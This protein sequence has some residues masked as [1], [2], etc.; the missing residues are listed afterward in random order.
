MDVFAEKSEKHEMLLREAI[1]VLPHVVQFWRER[2]ENDGIPCADNLATSSVFTDLLHISTIFG[3][4]SF[5]P[6]EVF[7]FLTSVRRGPAPAAGQIVQK[8]CGNHL[9]QQQQGNKA[10]SSFPLSPSETAHLLQE[11]GRHGLRCKHFVDRIIHFA[12][13]QAESAMTVHEIMD[14]ARG[15]IRFTKDWQ[16]FF[17]KACPKIRM[18]LLQLEIPDLLLTLRFSRDLKSCGYGSGMLYLE[19][20]RDVCT[21]LRKKML[22]EEEGSGAGTPSQKEN[23]SSSTPTGSSFP[24]SEA[25]RSL[26]DVFFDKRYSRAVGEY[27]KAVNGK[28][29]DYREKHMLFVR[30]REIENQRH[31][32]ENEQQDSH[33]SHDVGNSR[34]RQNDWTL[35]TDPELDNTVELVRGL[36]SLTSWKHVFLVSQNATPGTGAPG[37]PQESSSYQLQEPHFDSSYLQNLHFLTNILA[38]RMPEMKYS[39]NVSL[40]QSVTNSLS[41]ISINSSNCDSTASAVED[42]GSLSNM[43]SSSDDYLSKSWLQQLLPVIQDKYMLDRISFFQQCT[44]VTALARMKFFDKTAYD[45][46]SFMLLQERQLFTELEHLSPVLWAY[47]LMKYHPNKPLFEF[48]FDFVEEK[49]EGLNLLRKN[50]YSKRGRVGTNNPNGPPTSSGGGPEQQLLSQV[51]YTALVQCC[52][53]FVSAGW[54]EVPEEEEIRKRLVQLQQNGLNYASG[55]Q[56]VEQDFNQTSYQEP[57]DA[58]LREERAKFLWRQ[59]RLCKMLDSVFVKQVTRAALDPYANAGG[60]G[61]VNTTRL[62]ERL[63]QIAH[64]IDITVEKNAEKRMELFS[65]EGL[66][67]IELH[68]GQECNTCAGGF[69]VG[70]RQQNFAQNANNMIVGCPLSLEEGGVSVELEQEAAM[71]DVAQEQVASGRPTV[72]SI[73][74]QQ[75]PDDKADATTPTSTSFEAE[76]RKKVSDYFQNKLEPEGASPTRMLSAVKMSR[77]ELLHGVY[78]DWVLELVQPE[79][80]ASTGEGEDAER[81]NAEKIAVFLLTSNVQTGGSFIRK[82]HSSSQLDGESVMQNNPHS[83]STAFNEQ[84]NLLLDSDGRQAFLEEILSKHGV[85]VVNLFL[86]EFLPS[87]RGDAED[88]RGAGTLVAEILNQKLRCFVN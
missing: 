68:L 15:L 30:E 64:M 79:K 21:L 27:V 47:S 3:K 20:Q 46:I 65:P 66:K 45:S 34:I 13:D 11:T 18:N 7:D 77:N 57:S 56:D 17:H 29:A 14:S 76:I 37:G 75:G 72:S 59:K 2:V 71:L 78:C 55:E 69:S 49:V 42:V 84:V 38:E 12:A 19:L 67:R 4:H 82:T 24:L 6:G 25:I 43:T 87:G 85:K 22:L 33:S 62:L 86:P 28:L 80:T 41:R 74:E 31:R 1:P 50:F 81:Q 70:G 23:L 63:V 88:D 40:W 5:Y 35:L 32:Q 60:A 61:N 73:G 51:G 10:S 16:V 48:A 58:L 39:P 26:H 8:S 52:H 53:A 36:D 9:H 83:H 54:L 44:L